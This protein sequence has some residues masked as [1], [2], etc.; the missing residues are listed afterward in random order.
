MSEKIKKKT[1]SEDPRKPRFNRGRQPGNT[2]ITWHTKLKETLGQNLKEN[3][4][5]M[6]DEFIQSHDVKF[7]SE[8][9]MKKKWEPS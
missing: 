7:P 6:Y 8:L 1:Q 4:R 2:K 5:Q 3:P 9:P